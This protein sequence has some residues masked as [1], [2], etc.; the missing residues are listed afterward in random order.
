MKKEGKTCW[1]WLLLLVWIGALSGCSDGGSNGSFLTRALQLNIRWGGANNRAAANS[2]ESAQ[3]AEIVLAGGAPNG[4]NL[5]LRAERNGAAD[6]SVVTYS[7]PTGSRVGVYPLSITFFSA[8]GGSAGGGSVVGVAG[9]TVTIGPNTLD[10]LTVDLNPNS[11]IGSISV[12]PDQSVDVGETK[13]LLI[14][15]RDNQNNLLALPPSAFTVTTAPVGGQTPSGQLNISNGTTQVQMTGISGGPVNVTAAIDNLTSAAEPVCVTL[16]GHVVT[17]TPPSSTTIQPGGTLQFTGSETSPGSTEPDSVTWAVVGGDAN[18]TINV[19]GV[20][21]APNQ[22]GTYTV[23]AYGS[24]DRC[25]F[26]S[27][28]V[29]VQ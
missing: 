14:N 27:A 8:P 17:I 16:P 12:V 6:G 10:P 25:R 19:D 2:P 7:F 4:G 1:L 3:S 23:R 21:T 15:V 11:N 13:A 18:G 26:A 24:V 22:P 9:A 20:Y 29:T 28:T 5:S